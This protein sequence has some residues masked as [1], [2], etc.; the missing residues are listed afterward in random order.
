MVEP[1]NEPGVQAPD[2]SNISPKTGD[3]DD[4][5][6]IAAILLLSV[7]GLAAYKKRKDA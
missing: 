6:P 7:S 4:V 5:A 1:E 3:V 2:N